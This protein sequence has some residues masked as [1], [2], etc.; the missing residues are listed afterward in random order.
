[1]KAYLA[2]TG[3][4][5][6]LLAVAHVVRVVQERHLA[7]DPVFIVTTILALGL[8]GWAL[9]LYRGAPRKPAA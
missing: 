4:L 3:I 8:A 5:F 7:S 2:T 9:R 1:M 6:V